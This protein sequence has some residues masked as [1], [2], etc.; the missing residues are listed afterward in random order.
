MQLVMPNERP[1]VAAWASMPWRR[2]I[3]YPTSSMHAFRVPVSREDHGLELGEIREGIRVTTRRDVEDHLELSGGFVI[4]VVDEL[5][6]GGCV[7]KRVMG[8]DFLNREISW[9]SLGI[10]STNRREFGYRGSWR[11]CCAKHKAFVLT[12][13]RVE[14]GDDTRS[15]Y[16]YDEVVVTLT[17]CNTFSGRKFRTTVVREA[18]RIVRPQHYI[19]L[20]VR[21]Y[22]RKSRRVHRCPNR[23]ARISINK[24]SGNPEHNAH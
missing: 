5:E 1:Q 24:M 6:Y 7:S 4:W 21:V 16:V 8:Y 3:R 18:G 9:P 15:C 14:L 17:S 2:A 19:R 13:R 10:G 22:L 12:L 23:Q 20:L 11:S